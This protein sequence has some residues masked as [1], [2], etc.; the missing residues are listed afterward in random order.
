[1]TAI[2]EQLSDVILRS[3][4]LAP[5]LALA[6]GILASFLPC[7][8]STV[9][10]IVGYVS[11]TGQRDTRR[12]FLLSVTFAAGSAV[13]FTALGVTASLA[14]RLIGG[15]ASWWYLVLGVLMVLM[16]LQTWEIFEFIPSSYL[17]SKNTKRG[18]LG[19]FLAGILGGV[20]SSPCSTPML[21]V[22]LAVVAGKGNILWGILLLFLYSVGH[23]IL[24]VVAGTSV[25]F[26]QKLSH[27]S[28]YGKW[29]NFL[30][31]AMGGLMLLIGLYMF[32]LGF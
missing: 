28:T 24:A 3:G 6:A 12:A 27:S 32:Y 7:S 19:A 9:P 31:I 1:M 25:G 21:I 15:A 8:L 22:L 14:G 2:L 10:L 20:F 16:A 11:G 13:T 4:F 17:V 26:V 29:S 30:K 5:L 18:Y 23:G